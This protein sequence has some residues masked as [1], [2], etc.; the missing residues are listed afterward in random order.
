LQELG[1]KGL[2]K[3][4]TSEDIKQFSEQY[5]KGYTKAQGPKEEFADEVASLT[6]ALMVPAKN[7]TKFKSLLGAIGK[8]TAVKGAGETAEAFGAGPKTKAATEIGM[9]FLTG[10][11]GGKTANQFISEKY[12]AASSAIP[13]NDIIP[14]EKLIIGLDKV[15][16]ELLK[17]VTTPTKSEVLTP[18]RELRNKAAGGGM[19]AEDA[20]QAYRDINER[21][22]AKKLFEDL[23]K[24][25]RKL[26]RK[27]YDMVRDELRSS[28]S[29][30][31][32]KNPEFFQN[33]SEA[34]QAHAVLSK[35]KTVSDFISRNKGKI[36]SHLGGTIALELFAGQPGLAVGT[37]ATAAGGYGVVKSGELLYR[38]SKSPV[39][40]KHYIDVIEAA[41]Q[42][43]LPAT[44]KSLSLLN[45]EL[46]KSKED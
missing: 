13:K 16:Q 22:K 32:K 44:I 3:L 19:L 36:P 26:L 21:L 37:A 39:L 10:L 15:E 8:A 4:P 6:T 40:R 17:G 34:N 23:S 7:P 35:S 11:M 28:L 29:D 38:I 42:E 30:Y 45:K 18:L 14:T 41:S 20:V 9:L 5:T 43:N 2:E 12:K 25:E 31:G 24:D 33:W 46:E 27:R 1:R